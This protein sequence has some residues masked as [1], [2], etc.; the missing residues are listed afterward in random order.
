MADTI[1]T[2]LKRLLKCGR[3][4]MEIFFEK[5]DTVWFIIMNVI[6]KYNVVLRFRRIKCI[7]RYA[8]FISPSTIVLCFH[9]KKIIPRVDIR[10]NTYLL[11]IQFTILMGYV[12]I[13]CLCVKIHRIV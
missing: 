3:G 6:G 7:N 8:F 13:E 4:T 2:N 12:H 1:K 5:I 11:A 9:F 10:T